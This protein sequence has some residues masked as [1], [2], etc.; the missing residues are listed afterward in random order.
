MTAAPRHIAL[1]FGH[2]R[3]LNEGLSEFSRQLAMHVKAEAAKQPDSARWRFH[4]IL[5]K[6]WHGYFGDDVSYHELNDRMRVKHTWPAQL[7]VWHGLHQHMRFRPPVNCRHAVITVH[8]LNH[9]YEKQGLKLWWQNQRLKRQLAHADQLVAISQYTRQDLARTF[10]H[11][12]PVEVI[13]NGVAD[14]TTITDA[15]VPQLQGQRYMLHLS[16]MSP[17]KNTESIIQLAATWPEQ[18]FA[19]VGPQSAE[20]DRH[21]HS[22]QAMGLT[23]VR[24]FTD[25]SE[26]Q[27]AW[28]YRHCEAFIFPSLTEGFGLPPIEAM[29]FGR[30][31][32]V[33]DRTSLPEVCGPHA[34]YL[35]Q[36][37]PVS[38][39]RVIVTALSQR[40]LETERQRFLARYN[41]THAARQYLQTYG[42]LMES[43]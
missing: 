27:K 10:R 25:V 24:F 18:L 37:D 13:Y 6:Q 29:R 36:F 28:L 20:V 42:R 4:F 5:P 12:A 33:S 30:P 9:L 35:D 43:S 11:I 16:R 3:H 40:G 14:L 32:V 21:R 2:V 22:V 31:I 38:M 39:R 19:L 17:S 34:H 41:W 7:D 8:D 1:Q 15:P 26:A 23:N